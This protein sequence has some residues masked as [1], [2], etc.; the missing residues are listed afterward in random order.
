MSVELK[1]AHC[2]DQEQEAYRGTEMQPKRQPLFGPPQLLP[3]LEVDQ[4]EREGERCER[5]PA[6]GAL[7]EEPDEPGHQ[8]RKN[9]VD[10]EPTLLFWLQALV[11]QGNTPRHATH[12]AQNGDCVKGEPLSGEILKGRV[13]TVKR[14]RRKTYK[15]QKPSIA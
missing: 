3:M 7:G 12:E 2:C 6:H 14:K 13:T 11:C 9:A 8:R 15:G 10:K 5:H 1:V 4:I